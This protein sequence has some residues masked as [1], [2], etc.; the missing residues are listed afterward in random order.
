MHCLLELGTCLEVLIDWPKPPGITI[1][2]NFYKLWTFQLI[3]MT[4]RAHKNPLAEFK[5]LVFNDFVPLSCPMR[6]LTLCLKK[7]NN[8]N[9]HTQTLYKAVTGGIF[10][11]C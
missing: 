2:R 3:C 8:I 7:I 10:E 6:N 1:Q 5:V 9:V 11:Y 4:K